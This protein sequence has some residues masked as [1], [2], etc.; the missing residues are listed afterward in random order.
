[1][2]F[3]L[4]LLG[5]DV[6]GAIRRNVCACVSTCPFLFTS[7]RLKTLKTNFKS[8]LSFPLEQ[9]SHVSAKF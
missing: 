9:S 5:N 4:V 8:A 7:K 2:K 6:E 1:M 3:P